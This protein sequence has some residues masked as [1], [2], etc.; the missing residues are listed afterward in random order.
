MDPG[1]HSDRDDE[2]PMLHFPSPLVGEGGA[3][4]R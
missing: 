1:S 4:E 3:L 2:R